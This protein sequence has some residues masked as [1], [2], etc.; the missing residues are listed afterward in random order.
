V[1]GIFYVGTPLNGHAP[2]VCPES[3]GVRY[4]K[5]RE[6][7]QIARGAALKKNL[8]TLGGMPARG[9]SYVGVAPH[10]ALG[11]GAGATVGSALDIL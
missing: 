1:G 6:Q 9:H 11:P 8:G 2:L 10:F 7:I 3:L 5:K 4:S